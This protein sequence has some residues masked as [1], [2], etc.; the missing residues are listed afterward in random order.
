MKMKVVKSMLVAFAVVSLFAINACNKSVDPTDSATGSIN[1][2]EYVLALYD[3]NSY[4]VVDGTLNT[5]VSVNSIVPPNTDKPCVMV[6]Q[7]GFRPP[8]FRNPLGRILRDLKL[9]PDQLTQVKDFMKTHA[10]CEFG[11]LKQLRDSQRAIIKDAND[12]RKVVI[13]DL[14]D[15]VITPTEARAKIKEINIA[16]R[17]ALKNNPLNAQVQQGLKDCM[18]EFIANISSILNSEQL[19]KWNRFISSFPPRKG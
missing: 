13:Q 5:E 11:W 8:M 2:T 9:T 6:N 15:S 1:P 10:E 12:Q 17:E 4:D 3:V 19:I 7:S 16:T 14:K 18:D